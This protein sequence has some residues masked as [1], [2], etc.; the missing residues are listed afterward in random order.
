MTTRSGYNFAVFEKSQ[1]MVGNSLETTDKLL[2]EAK[3]RIVS[4]LSFNQ[5][6]YS[7][8]QL[9]KPISKSTTPA[10]IFFRP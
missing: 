9:Q 4:W 6:T 1:H 3:K 8:G 7:M 2:T 10:P 5:T